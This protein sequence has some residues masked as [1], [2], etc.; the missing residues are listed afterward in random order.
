MVF[1]ARAASTDET[2]ARRRQRHQRVEIDRAGRMQ[3]HEFAVAVAGGHVAADAELA[4]QAQHRD[5]IGAERGLGDIGAGQGQR[6][7]RSS[8]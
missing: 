8:S 4:Q 1:S 6:R 5:F 3:G 2:A 7:A